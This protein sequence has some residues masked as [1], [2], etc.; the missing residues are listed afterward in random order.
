MTTPLM[1][2]GGPRG[3]QPQSLFADKTPVAQPGNGVW[4]R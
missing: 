2:F 1:P 3:G 4:E